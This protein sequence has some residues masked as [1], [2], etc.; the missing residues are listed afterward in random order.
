MMFRGYSLWPPVWVDHTGISK[1][2][3]S[4]EPGILLKVQCHPDN[5]RRIFL[6]MEHEAAEYTACLLMEYEFACESIGRLLAANTGLTMEQV[7]SLEVPLAFDT[8]RKARGGN[9]VYKR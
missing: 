5:P 8:F 4:G 6:T 1:S 9:E 7:G 2:I 3:P